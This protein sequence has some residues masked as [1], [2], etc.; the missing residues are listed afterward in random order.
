MPCPLTCPLLSLHARCMQQ[1]CLTSAVSCLSPPFPA[2]ALH[3]KR[4]ANQTPCC[5]QLS[6]IEGLLGTLDATKACLSLALVCWTHQ[7]LDLCKL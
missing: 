6:E 2:G 5:A 3:S 4:A 7:H 1:C